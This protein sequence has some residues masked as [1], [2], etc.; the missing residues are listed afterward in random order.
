MMTSNKRISRLIPLLLVPV[1]FFSCDEQRRVIEPFVPSGNRVVL[2]EEITGKGC[3]NCPKGSR[4]IENLL[5]QFPDNL[6]V[7]SNHS[8]F[9]ANPQF[10]P[11]GQ[12]DLRTEE[13]EFLYS[14]L[15]PNLG[16][17]AG[18]VNRVPVNG[19]MQTSLNQWRDRKSVV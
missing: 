4:E 8:G 7:V 6:V 14:Y 19:D 5:V 16:Y 3:T 9:F 15:G 10:F 2:L 1:L 13:G 17:P 11:L 18:V 12:Y